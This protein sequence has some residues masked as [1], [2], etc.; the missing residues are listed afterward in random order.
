MQI[1]N[2]GNVTKTAIFEYP[3]LKTAES[4]HL[5]NNFIFISGASICEKL[6]GTDGSGEARRAIR[7]VLALDLMPWLWPWSMR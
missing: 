4:R 2:T 7:S 6:P 3:V 1:A 5:E